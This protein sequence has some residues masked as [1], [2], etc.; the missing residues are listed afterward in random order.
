MTQRLLDQRGGPALG[1]LEWFRP[2][3]HERVERAVADLQRLGVRYLRTGISWADYHRSGVHAWY[4][5]L[6]PTLARHFELLPCVLYV[7]PSLSRSK[8]T[9]GPPEDPKA[10]ADFLDV[11]VARHGRHFDAI[12]L[13]NEPNNLADW[14]WRLDPQWDAFASMIVQA[15]HWMRRKGKRTVL[16]GMCPLD[17]NWLRLMAERGALAEIDVVGLH[18][19]P[20]TWESATTSWLSW[21]EQ[22]DEVRRLLAEHALEP[23]IWITETG[24]S[25]WRFDALEPDRLPARDAVGTGRAGLLVQLSGP[26]P[27]A[28]EPGRLALRRAPLPFR[29][30]HRRRPAEAAVPGSGRGRDRARAR[31]PRAAA[32]GAGDRRPGAAR[33]RHRRRG[34]SR[35]QSL[36][37]A[38]RANGRTFWSSIRSRAPASRTTSP[39]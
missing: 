2:G 20:G 15:A 32:Q 29:P 34:L 36:P 37:N 27:V 17:L 31:D 14:D 5:W 19:F 18:G 33:D 10:Y 12:E 23:A 26:A 1:I 8:S 11:L 7:P 25:T 13:W 4:D 6:L 21:P 24:Y 38:S 35:L 16:G 3:E 9:A 22:V 39:G 30:G 28:A